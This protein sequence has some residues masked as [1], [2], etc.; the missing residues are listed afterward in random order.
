MKHKISLLLSIMIEN[1]TDQK[2]LPFSPTGFHRWLLVVSELNQGWGLEAMTFSSSAG[3]E[4]IR[5]L[6]PSNTFPS[7]QQQQKFASGKVVSH[8]FTYPQE[9]ILNITGRRSNLT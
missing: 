2:R 7:A 4:K 9:N 3:V 1:R 6:A 8:I 5:L